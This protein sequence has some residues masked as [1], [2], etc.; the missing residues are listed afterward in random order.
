MAKLAETTYRDVNIGLANQFGALRRHERHRR[1]PGHRGQQLPAL[2]PHPPPRHR[3]RRPLHP[4]LPAALP[5]ERPRRHRRARR[6]RGQRRHAGLH[7]R[8]A[9][10][11]C[12]RRPRPASGRR[13]RRRLP[14]RRQGDRVLRR[15][16]HR[17]RAARGRGR[18]GRARPDVHR[19][20]SSRRFGWDAYTSATRSTSSSSR[21]TTP[22]TASCPPRTSRACRSSSTAAASSTA[23]RFDGRRASCVVGQ[24]DR[25][26]LGADRLA[27]RDRRLA[28]TSPRPRHDRRRAPRSGTSPRCARAPSSARTASSAAA[29]T[30]A[31]A[32]RWATTASCRTTRWS[33]SRP[34]SEDGVF[35]GPAVVF[36]N[37]HYPRA[38]S[39][40]GTLKTR[41]RLGAG[42]RHHRRTGA[43]IGARAVCVAPVTIGR[44]ALVAAGVRRHQ[45]RP[46]LRPRGRVSRPG[47]SRWVGKAGVPLRA[48]ARTPV[49][50]CARRP[51][52]KYIET[53]RNPDGG[54]RATH[55]HDF[56]PAGQADHRRRGAGG[57][58]PRAAQRHARPGPRGHGVRGGVLRALRPRPRLRR[59]QLRHLR[60]APRPA[61]LR[62][63]GR[64]RGHRAVVHLRRDRQLRRA[65]RRHAGL[66]RHR[67]RRLLPRP[68]RG[69]GA[70]SPSGPSGIMPV[71]LYG[72]PAK[73][74]PAHGRSPTK[75]GIAA[76]R[77]RRPGPRRLA[78]RH[79]GRHLRHVRDV[80]ALPDEEHD[81]R[82]GR[83]GLGR[84][85]RG[86]A[87]ACGCSATRA[88]SGSTRTR[89][90]ASTPA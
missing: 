71:H 81:L 7:G 49:R 88:W 29:P 3:R 56:I 69:R 9:D 23:T 51:A 22:S 83:H 10:G 74:R 1:L 63:R 73:M 35:V 14:R 75:H 20:R 68:G 76:L 16:R 65:H 40:D 6:P 43:S 79:A 82:R 28:P 59:R 80:L 19:R 25:S 44:W 12:R 64:R 13:A 42:G 84:R 26:G 32:C 31:P 66:R 11:R 72:H 8:P 46:G 45:G 61:G 78:Q 17:R 18:R 34:C 37:D 62:R 70:R 60:P 27:V 36:T 55:E 87:A 4:G 86:R 77:G 90:S 58:R 48:R 38:V 85:R 41:R 39:P 2:Q 89:S 30:S 24:A 33:T 57:R 52:T 15:L 5:L 67:A 21:P 47:G 50:G 54:R 53:R